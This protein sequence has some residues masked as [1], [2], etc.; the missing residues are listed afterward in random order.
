MWMKPSLINA[1]IIKKQNKNMSYYEIEPAGD[2]D[3]IDSKTLNWLVKWA[4][5]TGSNIQYRIDGE[6]KRIGLP[7]FI[8]M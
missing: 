3:T 5:N 2:I 8:K 1:I 6:I 4:A 7:E